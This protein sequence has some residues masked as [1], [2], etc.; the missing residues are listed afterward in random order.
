MGLPQPY[1]LQEV[2]SR[3]FLGQ[4]ERLVQNMS[5]ARIFF[6]QQAASA[7]ATAYP[8]TTFDVK[9][10]TPEQPRR[11]KYAPSKK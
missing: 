9:A 3:Y 5:D 7:R 1:V 2:K 6:T 8:G 11:R 4:D 10:Y